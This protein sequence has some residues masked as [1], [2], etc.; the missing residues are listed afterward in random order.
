MDRI[1]EHRRK[2]GLGGKGPEEQ[3][4]F[5]DSLVSNAIDFLSRSVLDLQPRPKYSIMHFCSG[6]ELFLKAR[7][8]QEHWSLIL[9][10]PEDA[11]F[12]QFQ[13]GDFSSVTMEDALRRLQN[14]TGESFPPEELACF[15]RIRDHRNKVVHFFHTAYATKASKKLLEEIAAEQCKAWFY[16]HRRIRHP[17]REHF[18]HYQAQIEKLNDKLHRYR[19]FL[20][21]K[22]G[23]LKPEIA[24]AMATG[25]EFER[26]MSCGFQSRRIKQIIEPSFEADCLVCAAHRSFLRLPCSNCNEHTEVDDLVSAVCSNEACDSPITLRDVM[27]KYA[28]SYDHRDGDESP[29]MYCAGCA[30]PD[31]SVIPLGDGLFCVMCRSWH[32]S[33]EQCNYCGMNLVGFDPHLS[34][35]Y[36]CFLCEHAARDHFDRLP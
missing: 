31:E 3:Y 4:A 21:A 19:V 16:L 32:K 7:L 20:K 23:A 33:C 17:W 2:K 9:K 14:V 36:G 5:F 27:E 28:P 25:I 34:G 18:H 10:K 26:C 12:K 35:L 22:F 6:L 24:K 29:L 1:K 11:S 15:K 13:N 30:H 8:L